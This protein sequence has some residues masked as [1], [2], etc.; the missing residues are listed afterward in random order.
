M[1][2]PARKET[3]SVK[4]GGTRAPV[5]APRPAVG[6]GVRSRSAVLPTQ[7]PQWERLALRRTTA[8]VPAAQARL[9]VGRTDDPLEREADTLAQRLLRMPDPATPAAAPA[10]SPPTVRR[11]CDD[12]AREDE[13]LRRRTPDGDAPGVDPREAP[14]GVHTVLNAPGQPLDRGARAF[15]EPRL[16]RDL[17][18]VR[19]HTDGAAGRSALAVGAQAYAV[20]RHIAFAPGRYAPNTQDGR[21]LLGHELAHTIQQGASAPTLRRA[22]PPKPATQPATVPTP[23]PTDFVLNRVGASTTSRISFAPGSSALDAGAS[24]AV[25]SIKALAPASLR[26]IGYASAEEPATLAQDRADAVRLALTAAPNAVTVS[27]AVGNAAAT[28]TRSDYVGARSVEVLV[29]AAAPSTVNCAATNALGALVNPPT[30]PCPTMDPATETAFQDG[31]T[32]AK[33]AMARIQTAVT[34]TPD[35]VDAPVIDRFFG[36]H[37]AATLTTLRTNIG[38]LKAHVDGLAAVTQCGGQCDVGGCAEGPIAYNSGVGL[39]APMTL[40][41]PAFRGLHLNDRARNLIHE[42]AHGTSPLGGA[43][44]SGTLDLAYRH[45]RMLF[46]LSSADRLRNSDNY[47]LF[48]LFL[49]EVQTSGNAA[50]VPA[51]I[52]TPATDTLT[53]FS[54]AERPVLE[55]ALAKLEKRLTWANDW[56]GQLYGEAQGVRSGTT[57][58]AA[59]WA[60][61]LMKVAAKGF[62]LTAPPAAPTLTDQAK[63]HEYPGTARHARRPGVRDPLAGPGR[64]H[65]TPSGR[66]ERRVH[67]GGPRGSARVHQSAGNGAHPPVAYRVRPVA[68]GVAEPAAGGRGGDD[69]RA[70]GAGDRRRPRR[71]P[72]GGG[73]GCAGGHRL[74]DPHH[75]SAAQPLALAGLS[76]RAHGALADAARQA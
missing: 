61:D 54:A 40:C 20:G 24:A 55:L 50:A 60:E 38:N 21:Y 39:A 34:G 62:P 53:G 16:D 42:S 1:I 67:S 28:A 68:A 52:D 23:G 64:G 75:R 76:G 6:V 44:G 26:L 13:A 29:G 51:G 2:A 15:F 12:C 37:A 47:A 17:G 58:W 9:A 10:P 30:Q 8:G 33:D 25:V 35:A 31:L 72:V 73:A 27:S 66:G 45:E 59:S 11:V 43:A 36:N 4:T 48:A 32:V 57:T 7:N 41:V 22:P 14:P 65:S 74:A 5:A 49:R 70:P 69:L 56:V 46:H 3:T 18:E 63:T 19:I 71:R